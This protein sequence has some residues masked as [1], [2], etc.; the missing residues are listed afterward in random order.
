M[1]KTYQ[2]IA[3]AAVALSFAACTQEDDFIPQG[4]QKGAPLAIASAGVTNLTTRATITTIEETDYLTGGSM[5]VFVKSENT[6]T[7]YKGDNLEWNYDGS[8]KPVG[9]TVLYEADETTQQ[10]GAY[11]PYKETLT[12]GKYPVEL[13]E[14]FGDDYENYDYLYAD[15]VAVSTNPMSIQMNHLFSKVTVSVAIKGSTIDNNDAVKSVS[16]SNVPRTAVWA[17]PTAILSNYGSADQMTV[18]YANDVDNNETVDNYVGFA[19]PNEATTL[20][21]RVDMASG[22]VFR[23]KASISGGMTGGIHYKISLNVG[24]D[25]I[26]VSTVRIV[27]WGT[28]ADIE[29]GVA[30]EYLPNIDGTEYASLTDLQNAVKEKL[31]LE[32]ETSVTIGGYLSE[33]MH[34]A[35]ISTIDEVKNEG[36]VTNGSLLAGSVTYTVHATFADAVSL[37]TDGTTLTLLSNT[38]EYSDNVTIENKTIALDLNGYKLS[39]NSTENKR[40]IIE[41]TGTLT[42]RDIRGGGEYSAYNNSFFVYGILNIEGGTIHNFVSIN[43]T[44]IVNMTGGLLYGNNMKGPYAGVD[45]YGTFNMSGGTIS[46]KYVVWDMSGSVVNISGDAILTATSRLFSGNEGSV[47]TI[48]GGTWSHAPS[49]YVDTEN[50]IVTPNEDD[51]WSVTAKE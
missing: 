22:R 11:Y 26:E 27:P 4:N 7:R 23:G 19:F 24:K 3:L 30:D 32:G 50:Y 29:D 21:L 13:P 34:A 15:H 49:A 16:L 35:I 9:A 47:I 48:T 20:N 37:W 8:W 1:K 36:A 45:S 28:G 10:I 42:I 31:S 39:F 33:G 38:D 46:S 51:T 17:V 14:T 12:D 18:L 44:G 5:G 6:D 25:K 41:E 2:Y 43:S 40:I